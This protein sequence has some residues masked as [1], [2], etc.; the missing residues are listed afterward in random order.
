MM[1]PNDDVGDWALLDRLLTKLTP[2]AV[3]LRAKQF[4]REQQE[5]YCQNRVASENKN[6]CGRCQCAFKS[7]INLVPCHAC[8]DL[9][10]P[11]CREPATIPGKMIDG[12]PVPARM[13]SVCRVHLS[14]F[15]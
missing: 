8:H 3:I 4:R 10:C 1:E 12:K 14:I 5:I 6:T 11:D 7:R 15:D 2:T 9:I 13:V